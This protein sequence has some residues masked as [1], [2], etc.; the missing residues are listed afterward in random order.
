MKQVMSLKEIEDR[1]KWLAMRKHGI[2]GSEIAVIAGISKWSSPLDVWAVK[3]GKVSGEQPD[4]NA[5]YWGRK[6]ESS[7][8][9]WF[10]ETTGKRILKAGMYS[11]DFYDFFLAT[12]DRLIAG[13]SAGLEVK[14]ASAYSMKEWEN[15][16]IPDAYMLQVQWYMGVMDFEKYYVAALIGGNTPLW[17]EVERDE[18]MIRNLRDIGLEFWGHVVDGTPPNNL[19]CNTEITEKLLE[20]LYPGMNKNVVQL[21]KDLEGVVMNLVDVNEQIKALK[22]YKEELE[23]TLKQALGN[24][25]VGSVGSWQVC[26]KNSKRSVFDS[27]R[28]RQENPDIWNLYTQGEEFRRFS[29]KKF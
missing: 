10:S 22:D 27:K 4:N 29:L 7:V 13:E 25:E 28:F 2:G 1:P 12:P 6:L 21:D 17:Y 8:A 26:W 9:D 14:T 20:V 24:N 15:G 18:K 19:C 5:M 3:T 23:N 16:K 11:D